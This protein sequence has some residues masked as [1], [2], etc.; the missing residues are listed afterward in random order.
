MKRFLFLSGAAL[1]LLSCGT[2][3]TPTA[4]ELPVRKAC[5]LERLYQDMPRDIRTDT[6]DIA[7]ANALCAGKAD[8]VA[9]L[10]REKKLFWDELPAVDTPYGRF[11]GLDDI[12]GFAD[13]FL[14]KFHASSATFT[15]VFQTIGGGR[16]A[17][18][19]V[20]K[21]VVDGENE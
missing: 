17:L 3:A 20:F 1:L 21:F 10:F 8:E 14:T 2:P 9:G 18:E 4:D 7:F 15:P 6:P 19:G 11:E 16:I 13:G 12:R 5:L